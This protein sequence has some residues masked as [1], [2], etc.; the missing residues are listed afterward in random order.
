MIKG[1]ENFFC[2]NCGSIFKNEDI[3]FCSICNIPHHRLEMNCDLADPMCDYCFSE[4]EAR[5]E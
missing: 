2:I 4:A 3:V 1:A 5:F